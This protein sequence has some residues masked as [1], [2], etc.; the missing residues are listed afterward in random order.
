DR[1]P[2][3]ETYGCFDRQYWHYR[4]VDFPTA[5]SQEAVLT[6]ALLYNVKG[7]KYY[8]SPLLLKWINAALEFWTKIQSNNGSFSEW[9]PHENSFV[10]TAFSS[11]T[12]SETILLMK[13]KIRKG[14][15]LLNALEK[16]CNW[17]STK[18]ESTVQNQESGMIIT[19]YNTYLITNNKHYKELAEEKVK[20]MLN[21]Q[22][23]E[24]WFYEY[25]GADIGYL[26]LTIDYLA[27]YYKKSKDKNALK[28]LNNAIDFISNFIHPNLTFGGEYASRN[29]EYIIPHGFEIMSR[30][31]RK[32]AAISTAIKEA[33]NKNTT[34][35]P[36]SLDDRYLTYILYNWLQAYLDSTNKKVKITIPNFQN[37]KEAGI[38]IINNKDYY[39]V[40]NYKKGGSF[41]LFFKKSNKV[42]YDSG[43]QIIS[44]KKK[45]TSGLLTDNNLVV[46]DKDSIKIYGS[47]QK[48]KGQVLTPGKNICLRLFQ[49]F[50][51]RFQ[52]IAL[53]IKSL[54]RGSLITINKPSKYKFSREITIKNKITLKDILPEIKLDKLILGGKAS[55]TYIPSSR[56]FQESELNVEQINL[57]N[58]KRTTFVREYDLKGNL[59]LSTKPL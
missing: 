39:L 41:K 10:A 25:G 7:T 23:K 55:Y 57:I 29:T 56:Y 51:G 58:P 8:Q 26:S 44:G 17:L 31:N 54:L 11:Y 16:A 40:L 38:I 18:T 30:K 46:V 35:A 33:L 21:R 13:D 27:K 6:L 2:L 45:F 22:T 9:Y 53:L 14:N 34:I 19:F 43:I 47:L 49:M 28:M 20:K 5:R 24:G 52:P 1:N 32:A 42:V 36:K 15:T 3:S 50:L 48:V 59:N 12:I 4:T 37:F